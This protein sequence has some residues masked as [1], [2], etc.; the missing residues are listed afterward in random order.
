MRGGKWDGGNG[1]GDAA[2]SDA[3][4]VDGLEGIDYTSDRY[5]NAIYEVLIR[6]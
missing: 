3:G 5:Q 1:K 6:G 4:T 2:R